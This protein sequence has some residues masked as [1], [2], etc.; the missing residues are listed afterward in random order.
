MATTKVTPA[1][2]E[3]VEVSPATVTLTLSLD[4]ADMLR[5]ALGTFLAGSL[6]SSIW[7]ALDRLNGVPYKHTVRR[8]MD[9]GAPEVV[10][11][12]A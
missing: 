12:D 5:A 3:V 9:G 7:Y 2:T 6:T 4:E 11:F 8:R 1:K 10:E